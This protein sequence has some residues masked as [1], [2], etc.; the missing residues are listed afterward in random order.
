MDARA[1]ASADVP[2]LCID[3]CS[4]LDMMRDPTREKVRLH[5][6]QA[7]IDLVAIAEAG[8]LACLMADQVAIE[9][10]V[11]DQRIQDDAKGNLKK[12]Q[13]Q[14][15]HINKLSA[16]YGAL[17]TVNLTHLDDHVARTREVVRRWLAKLGTVTPGASVQGKALTRMI[18]GVAPA[19]RGKDSS[20]DCLIYETYIEAIRT[21][22][23]A[24][25][26]KPIV[27]LSSNTTDYTDSS[28][29]RSEIANEFTAL[30]VKY[31]PNMSAAKH[32]LGL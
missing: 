30:S 17:G 5:E 24:G 3:T 1:I 20:G 23:D 6:R 19:R 9:F 15:Q 31:A 11:H 4:I 14:I 25:A 16:V 8:K 26:K 21:L 28:I 22:R 18:A 2:V 32:A 12:L 29:L 10:A 27:F 13:D 7:G